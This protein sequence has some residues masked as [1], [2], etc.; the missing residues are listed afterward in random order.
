MGRLTKEEAVEKVL[1]F[2]DTMSVWPMQEDYDRYF[3]K[4]EQEELLAALGMKSSTKRNRV[5]PF[6]GI[7]IAVLRV[8]RE[9][10]GEIVYI[11]GPDA[12][13]WEDTNTNL[14]EN[15]VEEPINI[16]I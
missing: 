6:A 11:A 9:R 13:K 12:I 16:S 4:T 2:R 5:R 14:F 10:K 7:N 8:L 1:A 15:Q 3:T